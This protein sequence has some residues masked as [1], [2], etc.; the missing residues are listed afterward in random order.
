MNYSILIQIGAAVLLS[1]LVGLERE[2]KYQLSKRGHFAGFRTFA[3][4][5]MFGALSYILAQPYPI[6]FYIMASGMFLFIIVSYFVTAGIRKGGVGITSEMA[7]VIMYFVGIICA[8]EMYVLATSIALITL[9]FLHFKI[10]LHKWAKSVQDAE[11]L[12]TIQFAIIAFVVLPILPNQGY[13]PYEIFNPYVI[14]L[15]VVLISGI[16]FLSY[17]TIKVLGPKKGIGVSGFLGGLISSTALTLSF[18]GE[19]KKNPNI[20]YPYVF[21][22]IVATIAMFFRVLVAVAII[23]KDLLVQIAVPVLSMGLAGVACAWHFWRKKDSGKGEVSESIKH[24]SFKLKSPFSLIPALKFTLLFGIILFLS[25]FMTDIYGDKGLYLTSFFSGIIDVDATVISAANLANSTLAI[26]V[27]SMAIMIAVATNT[28]IK[29]GIFMF[30]G[31]KKV[32]IRL[33]ESFLIMVVC[34]GVAM[35]LEKVL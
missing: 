27:A 11:I 6:L 15:M 18:S 24:Q 3:L 23:D 30:F 1:G 7:T 26:A 2:Q 9:A 12:S 20:V 29:G 8:M 19:S 35:I 25:R 21:S 22:V 32:A 13:G 5:G 34:G 33:I 4:I 14:W 10:P 16:S 17:V 31:N 28:L